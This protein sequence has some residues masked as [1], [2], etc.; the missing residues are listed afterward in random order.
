MDNLETS[1]EV[2][3]LFLER[4]KKGEKL[5][6]ILDEMTVKGLFSK[7]FS[8]KSNIS[9]KLV[10]FIKKCAFSDRCNFF[11]LKD[12][13]FSRGYSIIAKKNHPLM[14]AINHR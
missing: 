1:Y 11:A 10:D 14:P 12:R 8:E 2:F 5:S 6:L 7:D 9:F 4:L 13:L 3:K